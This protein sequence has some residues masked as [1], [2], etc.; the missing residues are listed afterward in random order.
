M[1]KMRRLAAL[2][3]TFIMMFGLATTVHA[4]DITI[5][6]DEKVS[7]KSTYSAYKLLS[8]EKMNDNS[9]KY[10]FTVESKYETILSTVT[11][12]TE[13][14]EIIKCIEGLSA[15]EE[16][17]AFAGD[18]YSAIKS[19]D[20][21]AD[22]T[23]KNGVIS[24]VDQGYYLIAETTLSSTADTYSLVML[25][26][27]GESNIEITTKEG[28]PTVVKFV[29]EVN[30]S[31]GDT[32][33]G[34]SADHDVN[35]EIAYQL[36]GTVSPKY[37]EY[38]S[39]YYSFVDT[40]EAGLTLLDNT[41]QVYVGGTTDNQGIYVEGGVNVTEQFL[42]TT[43]N[44]NLV[45][46]ANLK[47]LTGVTITSD[48]K[49]YVLYS[50]KLNENALYGTP[51]NKNEVVLKYENDPY[52]KD[53]DGDN[54]PKTPNEPSNPGVTPKD[55]NIVFTF[56]TTVNKVDSSNS[57]LKGAGFTLYKKYPAGTAGIDNDGYKE[58]KA[59]TASDAT[60]FTFAGLDAGEYKLLET[61]VPSGY[62]KAADIIFK[63]E[64]TY[65]TEKK[66]IE[67]AGLSAKD[68]N[69]SVISSTTGEN[70]VFKVTLDETTSDLSTTVINKPGV[71]L[72]TTGGIGTT[73]FYVA[74]GILVVGAVVL[75]VTKKR[76]NAEK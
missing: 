54:N 49:I 50:A 30:D 76:M 71:T 10:N 34:K 29:K 15:G 37:S 36:I 28:E 56:T 48:T 57:P 62:N 45:V 32:S 68:A 55:I 63:V 7:T 8:A 27:A 19:A 47:E 1:R 72:P 31:T 35:D 12:E 66:P 53:T 69:G 21:D 17:N 24:G 33:W 23:S 40:M 51:G 4:V 5:K 22:E 67:L 18:V 46:T 42:I 3:L 52:H 9:G 43:E 39:Y 58:Y 75:L 44:N 38:E 2:L 26:T 25:N 61:T 11:G 6:Q 74:G 13:H 41:V 64:A 14:T 59:F 60:T 16:I 65:D 70:V 20:L 73:I